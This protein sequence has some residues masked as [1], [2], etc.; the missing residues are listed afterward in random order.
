MSRPSSFANA[1]LNGAV[2]TGCAQLVKIVIQFLSVIL[3]SRLL[4]PEDFGVVA[5]IMPLVIFVSTF[6]EI[7]LQ[8]AIIQRPEIRDDQLNAIFWI[9]T[10]VGV[11]CFFIVIM[12]GPAAV[13][14]YN[15]ERLW[16]VA[17]VAAIPIII[18]NF[19]AIHI[20]LMNRNMRFKA[21]AVIDTLSAVGGF[22]AAYIGAKAGL[23]YW[24]I[25]LNPIVMAIIS[26]AGSNIATHWRPSRPS[27]R[28]EKD[29]FYFGANLT[30]FN[31]IIFLGRNLDVLLIGR[32]I[33]A[34]ALGYYDRAQRL[35]SFPL[36]NLNTP[37]SRVILPIL[38]RVSDDKARLRQIYLRTVGMLTLASVPGIA[39]VTVT[40][41]EIIP[42][43]LGEKWV[44]VIPI[45]W[46][47]GVA[48]L[49]LPLSFT[50]KWL[51]IA[52]GKTKLL[53]YMG[54]YASV[55]TAIA[56]IIGVQWGAVGV[57][58]GYA[59]S[60]YLLKMPV[61]YWATSRVSPVRAYDLIRVQ[62]P[63]FFAAAATWAITNYLREENLISGFYLIAVSMICAYLFS[64][65]A[66]ATNNLGRNTIKEAIGLI[67]SFKN[68]I[69][70][71]KP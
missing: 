42:L 45:F 33:G 57:A 35:L 48:S 60:S 12:L 62:F 50:E 29:I 8:Q 6:Q 32:Y 47:L 37:L 39:A 40:A 34:T 3:I 70:S 26:C 24:A 64:L 13:W 63:L 61:S 27:F 1:A 15:D 53:F 59:I 10:A 66:V 46:W 38:S 4:T 19:N 41:E 14:F 65:A 58:A 71:R 44:G 21:L 68:R 55:T 11:V 16:K 25:M 30:G 18:N 51:Y 23:G 20:S 2:L 52:Q 31:L 49:S 67:T 28:I 36:Q 5:A 17:I 43:L 54:I 69:L 9:L 56:F 7:G 22:M